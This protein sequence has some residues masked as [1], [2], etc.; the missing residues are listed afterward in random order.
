[1]HGCQKSKPRRTR[2]RADGAESAEIWEP[3][4][5][6]QSQKSRRRASLRG[7]FLDNAARTGRRRKSPDLVAS[8]ES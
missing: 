5:L 8:H 6:N 4:H 7:G 2:Q 1:M 3:L